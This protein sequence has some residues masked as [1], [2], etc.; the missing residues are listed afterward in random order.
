MNSIAIAPSAVLENRFASLRRW[1]VWTG[2]AALAA[3]AAIVV[4][5][6]S[7]CAIH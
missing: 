1:L 3:P 5:P 4:R 2:A 6:T 7:W